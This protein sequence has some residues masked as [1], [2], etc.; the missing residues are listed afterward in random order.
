VAGRAEEK[1]GSATIIKPQNRA[2]AEKRLTRNGRSSA[3][4]SRKHVR[5]GEIPEISEIDS[6]SHNG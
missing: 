1:R 4:N 2:D 5:R 6:F 3:E